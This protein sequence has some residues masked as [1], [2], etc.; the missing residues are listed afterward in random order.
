M[1]FVVSLDKYNESA[2]RGALRGAAD[3]ILVRADGSPPTPARQVFT[4]MGAPLADDARLLAL[5][6]SQNGKPTAGPTETDWNGILIWGAAGS[7]VV[8]L[9]FAFFAAAPW[10]SARQGKKDA[11]K[12]LKRAR[13]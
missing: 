1:H 4:R 7:A 13:R 3:S 5:V 10:L 9:F 12:A 2:L 8:T 11:A 6:P